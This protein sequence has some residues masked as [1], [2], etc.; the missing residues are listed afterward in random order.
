M[1][2]FT[3]V[4]PFGPQVVSMLGFASRM[5]VGGASLNGKHVGLDFALNC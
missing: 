2:R 4:I 5:V 3:V 1:S